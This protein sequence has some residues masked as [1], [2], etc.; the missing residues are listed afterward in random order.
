[1]GI[2][3]FPDFCHEFDVATHHADEPEQKI[4]E[5]IPII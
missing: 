1:M 4:G 2:S 3:R 5:G